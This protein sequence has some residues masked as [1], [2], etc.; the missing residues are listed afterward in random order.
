MEGQLEFVDF[1]N[2]LFGSHLLDFIFLQLPGCNPGSPNFYAH[3]S[4]KKEELVVMNN[5]SKIIQQVT[6]IW[7]MCT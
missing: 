1:W 2:A 6:T 7:Y 3:S 5:S 4:S